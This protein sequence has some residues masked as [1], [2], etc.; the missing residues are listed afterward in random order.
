[1][2]VPFAMQEFGRRPQK[3]VL[4]WRLQGQ[5]YHNHNTR[6]SASC[7]MPPIVQ[8]SFRG[9]AQVRYRLSTLIVQGAVLARSL[10]HATQ[11]CTFLQLRSPCRAGS[12]IVC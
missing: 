7:N 12:A 4:K 3:F 10:P 11:S 9:A 1:M 6:A 5:G 2:T 8:A